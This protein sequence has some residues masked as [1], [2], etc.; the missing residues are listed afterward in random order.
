MGVLSTVNL[1]TASSSSL[2]TAKLSSSKML[3]LTLKATDFV[4]GTTTT[5]EPRFIG[6]SHHQI[7]EEDEEDDSQFHSARHLDYSDQFSQAQMDFHLPPTSATHIQHIPTEQSHLFPQQWHH[8]DIFDLQNEIFQG[9]QMGSAQIATSR[10]NQQPRTLP[11]R[12]LSNV[13]S[14]TVDPP[15][16]PTINVTS[17]AGWVDESQTTA[18][19]ALEQANSS[20]SRSRGDAQAKGMDAEKPF[21]FVTSNGRPVKN[22]PAARSRIK[23]HVMRQVHQKRRDANKK[24]TPSTSSSAQRAIQLHAPQTDRHSTTDNDSIVSY[25]R[26]SLESDDGTVSSYTSPLGPS[27]GM[28]QVPGVCE[29]NTRLPNKM[30]K[31][32]GKCGILEISSFGDEGAYT[33]SP[34][35][36]VPR[37]GAGG[38]SSI[39][40]AAL[41]VNFTK[42]MHEMF[43]HCK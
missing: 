36:A 11:L 4:R 1:F 14:S 38:S 13:E 15:R 43:H 23:A 34:F 2:K 8:P 18:V 22:D 5:M 10:T 12:Q 24:A 26:R 9:L 25:S 28:S 31:A 7:Q 42:T 27:V 19:R 17:A 40:F 35:P 32:C 3:T 29:H 20:R 33:F 21:Q 39:P 6:D 16:P 30:L 37:D 41:P